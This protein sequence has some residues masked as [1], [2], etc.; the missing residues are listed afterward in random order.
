MELISLADRPIVDHCL[1]AEKWSIRW[2]AARS[3]IKREGLHLKN[4]AFTLLL[5]DDLHHLRVSDHGTSAG[6]RCQIDRRLEL[7]YALGQ[8]TV[9]GVQN[10]V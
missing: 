4:D 9:G 1:G 5:L 6:C 10:F 3:L 2:V 7:S 8:F